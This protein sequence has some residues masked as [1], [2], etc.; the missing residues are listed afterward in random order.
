MEWYTV[1]KKKELLLYEV[2]VSIVPHIRTK[3]RNQA[4]MN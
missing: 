1:M 3:E 2:A 4:Q